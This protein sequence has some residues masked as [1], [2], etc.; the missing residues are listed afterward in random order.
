MKN[1]TDEATVNS[2]EAAFMMET[3]MEEDMEQ[4]AKEVTDLV[5]KAINSSAELYNYVKSA[6]KKRKGVRRTCTEWA[7]SHK[8]EFGELF[9]TELELVHWREVK[10]RV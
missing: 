8:N 4:Y 2:K 5:V 10:A 7:K 9:I 3:S 1:T 6:I